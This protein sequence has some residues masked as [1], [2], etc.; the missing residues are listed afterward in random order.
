VKFIILEK[1]EEE[2]KRRKEIARQ[3]MECGM[4][5]VTGHHVAT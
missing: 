4:R 1:E 5:S 2:E 3:P